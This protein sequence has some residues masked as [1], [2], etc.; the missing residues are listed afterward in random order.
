ME[1]LNKCL[2]LL[3]EKGSEKSEV[4]LTKEIK[5]ELNVYCGEV[6]LLRTMEEYNLEIT[7][8]IEGKKDTIKINQVDD[9]SIEKAINEVINNAKNSQ[10]DEAND[11]S[12][13]VLKKTFNS[14]KTNLDID[15]M[16]KRLKDF[17][18]KIKNEIPEV[19]ISEAYLVYK[20]KADYY[21]NSNGVK[22]SSNDDNYNFSLV[23]SSRKDNKSSSFN[24]TTINSKNLD[25]ELYD[26][27]SLSYILKESVEHL[28]PKPIEN[29]KFKGDIIITPDCMS[30]ILMILC[31]QLQNYYLIS[32]ISKFTGKLNQKILDE[33]FS[34]IT[35]PDSDSLA[36]NNYFGKDG[37]INKNDYIIKNGVLKNYLVDL[38]GSKKTGFERGPSLGDNLIV[39]AGNKSF[40]EM[41]KTIDKGIILSRFSGGQPAPNGDFSGI[42]K[43][44]F[45]V[46]NGEI[47]H[48]IKETMISGNL[49]DMFNNII[50]ISKERINSGFNLLP[51]IQF[52]D[53]IISSK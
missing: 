25:K 18:R 21:Y 2:K 40:Q 19:N 42:A 22:L 10:K 8:I 29:K 34:L 12:D 31:A 3:Q 33:K 53:I 16:H 32:G 52:T 1:L 39:E 41:I 26:L 7:A 45:Y 44:S 9:E 20:D 30:M 17:V 28:N 11:I 27:G 47:K 15:L 49:F 51:F 13:I 43:N 50:N 36:V 35:E 46:E 5:E 38:Y 24:Y 23:F 4:Y 6:G 14:N 48:A 37:L